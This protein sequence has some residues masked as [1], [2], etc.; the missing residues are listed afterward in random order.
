MSLQKMFD[1]RQKQAKRERFHAAFQTVKVSVAKLTR[2]GNTFEITARTDLPD[3]TAQV[4]SHKS[5]DE[6]VGLLKRLSKETKATDSANNCPYQAKELMEQMVD[7]ICMEQLTD[8]DSDGA[9]SHDSQW[10]LLT[11]KLDK[12]FNWYLDENAF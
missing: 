7:L 3:R 2:Q 9:D 5:Y 11:M 1:L 4:T 10:Q 8:E 12:L 6:M